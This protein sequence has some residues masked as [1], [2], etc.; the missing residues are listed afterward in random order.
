MHRR[1]RLSAQGQVSGGA[2][3][4]AVARLAERLADGL[5]DAVG[6]ERLDHEVLGAELDRLEHLGLLAEGGAHDHAGGR[7]Q[8][9]DLLEGGE[10]VLLGHRDVERHHLRLELLEASDR[11]RA[12]ADLSDHFVAA[13]RERVAHHLPHECG[14]VDY[15]DSGH[16]ATSIW[17][18]VDVF[19]DDRTVSIR[20]AQ[21]VPST[22]I[23][24]PVAKRVPLTY[25][26]IGSSAAWLSSTTEPDGIA[27]TWP[28]GIRVRPS[29]A[30][31]RTGTPASDGRPAVLAR[32]VAGPAAEVGSAGGAISVPS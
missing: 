6:L 32:L 13:L 23:R 4:Q 28:D 9:D 21:S 5:E 26:S 11:L 18:S 20:T 24:R 25:R 14:V 30:H 27:T 16:R 19:E 31:T 8:L 1:S 15:Q 17:D 22:T 29:S 7:V 3:K 2:V 10:A 12:V